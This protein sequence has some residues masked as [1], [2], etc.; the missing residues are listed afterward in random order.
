VRPGPQSLDIP[1]LPTPAYLD[2]YVRSAK[3]QRF[4]GFVALGGGAVIGGTSAAFLLWN[5]GQKHDAERDFNAFADEVANMPTHECPDDACDRKLGILV[6]ELDARRKRDVY[7]WVGV[8]IGAASLGTGVV[9]LARA[10]NP[11]R[12]E[13]KPESDVFGALELDVRPSGL[14]LH[15]NF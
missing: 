11:H 1:L 14:S 7:G 15:G 9:L 12:Y 6:D 8:A 4:W 5:Q 10:P 3:T 13:P 2:D